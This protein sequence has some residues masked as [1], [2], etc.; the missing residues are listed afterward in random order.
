MT[1]D[2]T[3]NRKLQLFKNKK[4]PYKTLSQGIVST[5]V[6]SI[7]AWKEVVMKKRLN[8]SF[9]PRAR[10]FFGNKRVQLLIFEFFSKK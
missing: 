7:Q 4:Q 2:D 9:T 8:I 5:L 3:S 1:N 6:R 10:R